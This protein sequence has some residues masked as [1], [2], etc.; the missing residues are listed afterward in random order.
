MTGAYGSTTGTD[1]RGARALIDALM[2][3]DAGRPWAFRAT[4]DCALLLTLAWPREKA[5]V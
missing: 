1:S 4:S 3:I 2:V 5:D